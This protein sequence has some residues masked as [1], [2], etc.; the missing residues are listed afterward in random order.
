MSNLN[1]DLIDAFKW[2][3]NYKFNVRADSILNLKGNV[4]HTNLP[5]CAAAAH[6]LN[7]V[8]PETFGHM[9]PTVQSISTPTKKNKLK[10]CMNYA[11]YAVKSI[12]S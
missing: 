5:Q 2:N 12:N 11:P 7:P 8:I 10:P 3:L 4:D 9:L 6:S 1:V